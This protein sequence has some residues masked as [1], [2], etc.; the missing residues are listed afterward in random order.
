MHTFLDDLNFTVFHQEMDLSMDKL[1]SQISDARL[2]NRAEFIY[3][4]ICRK[5]T[6]S[7]KK[8]G[9]DRA[10]EVA[11]S[12]FFNNPKVTPENLLKGKQDKLN[13]VSS[14]LHVLCIQDSSEINF[15]SHRNRTE[16]LGDLRYKNVGLMLHPTIAVNAENGAV[17]GAVNVKAWSRPAQRAGRA[18]YK[19]LTTIEK[20][21]IRWFE[22]AET[23]K[24]VLQNASMITVVADRESDCYRLLDKIP[25]QKTHILVRIAQNRKLEHDEEGI[26]P[27]RLFQYLDNLPIEGIYD[28]ETRVS[29]RKGARKN[30]K[31][32]IE[33]RFSKVKITKPE[34]CF[35][36][37]VSS[38]VEL[39]AIDVRE[40]KEY[41]PAGE[42]ALHWRLFTSHEIE[43]IEQACECVFW[44]KQRWHIEQVF[45]L[46]KQD[47]I[48]IEDSM[49]GTADGLIRLVTMSVL[50]AV[51]IYQ[52]MQVRDGEI[53]RKIYEV[54]DK[55]EVEAMKKL[56]KRLEG[57]TEKQKNPH[58]P[59]S[60]SWAA[61]IVARLGGWTGY[62]SERKPG[63]ITFFS[64]MKEL[65][66]ILYGWK[67]ATENV[68]IP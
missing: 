17:L 60:L 49:L 36:A 45:R 52:L 62:A 14:N 65:E 37:D 40:K 42:K 38:E 46:C 24:E 5:K 30:R 63:P 20:E 56:N 61:W 51:Q 2:N 27:D 48:R 7:L 31:T 8:L 9:C 11:G 33:I 41:T 25:D 19:K 59:E 21:S 58:K 43:T 29:A 34:R 10:G 55:A 12:R 54:F 26:I 16:G 53:N 13:E 3:N 67:M 1:N 22:E 23:S 18:K 6:I 15:T 47:G 35:D 44:Y 50:A 4:Q 28:F 39:Y 66:R 57:K 32:K 68:C 64:G